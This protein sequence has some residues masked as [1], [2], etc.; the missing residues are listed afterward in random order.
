MASWHDL[1]EELAR[2]AGLERRAGLW[3]RDDDAVAPGPRLQNL[4]ELSRKSEVPAA[5]AVIPEL[6]ED[7][8]GGA[9]AELPGARMLV[10]GL[11]HENRA[12]GSEK[13]AEFG[14]HRPLHEMQGEAAVARETL[15]DRFP[16]LALPVF[17]P[18][19]NRIDE[20]LLPRLPQAGLRG[21]SRFG[22][23]TAA[24]TADFT[25]C[26]CHLD[27]IDWHGGRGFIGEEPALAILTAHLRARRE[28]TV[29]ASESSGVLSHHAVME[30]TGWDF[31]QELFAR[32]QESDSAHWLTIDE[33]FRLPR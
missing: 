8:L 32:T 29:D 17:V 20:N 1:D 11:R 28:G 15:A 9:L 13:K 31:L 33:I 24:P 25:E 26:N 23:R 5:I 18:P 7:A 22:P 27:L 4:I 21:L 14:P 19:W 16:A 3:W 12:P 6:A 30:R 2:W 10:H